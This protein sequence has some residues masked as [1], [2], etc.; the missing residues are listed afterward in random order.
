MKNVNTMA[1]KVP[2][3]MD[4]SGFLRSPDI[5]APA[6]IPVAAGKKIAKAVQKPMLLV[7]SGV[8]EASNSSGSKFSNPPI[9]KLA[10]EIKKNS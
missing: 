4:L 7:K 9:T 6:V 10:I 1:S 3:G 8:L 2:H 5:L